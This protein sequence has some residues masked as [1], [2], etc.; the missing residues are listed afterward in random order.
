MQIPQEYFKTETVHRRIGNDES[1]GILTCG[2]IHKQR[3]NSTDRNILFEHYGAL[4]LLSG[5]G[6]HVDSAGK[7]YA[8]SPGCFIQR[9]PGK[10]HSAF[11]KPDGK[12]LEFF[13]CFGR[14]VFESLA[15]INAVTAAQDVLYPGVNTAIFNDF[16]RF[17]AALR[18]APEQDLPL[19]LVEAQRI[20][21]TIYR[22]HW[23]NSMGQGD[24][25]LIGQACRLLG[26]PERRIPAQQVAA[27]LGVGYE[28]FRKLFAQK[29]G[30]P[31]YEY[32]IQCRI[33]AA[34]SMLLERGESVKQT[35][36]ALGFADTFT[37]SRQFAKIVGMPPSQY[38]KIY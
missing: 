28:K 38:K 19:M 32:A 17:M 37:F 21:L 3:H 31:P 14:G 18:A 34:K 30:M 29:M 23:R 20:I 6:T 12:W 11:V 35:A 1:L 13:I 8:L 36:L 7:E 22:M 26:D 4:L 5:E 10:L 33:N 25:E 15:A 27:E 9:I 24:M 16:L 2:F